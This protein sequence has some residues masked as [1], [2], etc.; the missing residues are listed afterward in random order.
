MTIRILRLPCEVP[1]IL[2]NL[3]QIWSFWTDFRKSR[4]YKNF[5]EIRRIGAAPMH[6]DRGH[7]RRT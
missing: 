7:D 4:Q 3:N 6:A 2:S 1:D 5:A